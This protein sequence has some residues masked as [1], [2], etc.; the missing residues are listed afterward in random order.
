MKISAP[1]KDLFIN[2]AGRA[3]DLTFDADDDLGLSAIAVR[4]TKVSGSGERFT[5]VEDTSRT[6]ALLFVFATL[7]PSVS[8]PSPTGDFPGWDAEAH[9]ALGVAA[10]SAACTI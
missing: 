3:L 2:D 9:P 4:Y 6:F 1:A 8:D 5:F 7:V 10:G